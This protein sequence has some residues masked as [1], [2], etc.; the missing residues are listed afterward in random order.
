MAIKKQ[1][2][3]KDG[4]TIYPD[5]GLNLD[6]VVYSDDPESVGDDYIDPASYSTDE[7]KTGGTWID[8]KPIYKKT[9]TYNTTGV[10]DFTI[11]TGIS[12]GDSLVKFES[13][14]ESVVD[15][16]PKYGNLPVMLVDVG[17]YIGV[18]TIANDLSSIRIIA[19]NATIATGMKLRIT[20]YYT[21][22]TD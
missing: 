15:A 1:L 5:V 8:G 22:T 3:D 20:M 2:K 16:T 14:M 13:I 11:N 18:R 21:K 19:N 9:I 4:N 7:K 6:D 17:W 10:L 12:N